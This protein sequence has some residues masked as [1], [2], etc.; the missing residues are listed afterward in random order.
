MRDNRVKDFFYPGNAVHGEPDYGLAENFVRTAEAFANTTYQSVYI[1]DYFRKN[2]L[3]VSPNPLFLCGMS[4]DAVKSE[5]YQFYID[6]VPAD[7]VEMLLEINKVGFSFFNDIPLEEKL[8]YTISY[9]FHL[10]NGREKILINHKLTALACQPDGSVWLG[11]SVVSLSTHSNPGHIT[12][13]C[14]GQ[15]EYW[16]YDLDFHC[17]EKRTTPML[18]ET[19]KEILTLSMQGLTINDI[20]ERIHRAV[21]SVKSA[22]RRLFEKLEV[23]NISEAISYATNY[24]LI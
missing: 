2:F 3:Y 11:L 6:H 22:R 15:S 4:A 9:D 8:K 14:R 10:V 24:K 20:A 19:E 7:E 23:N 5:G 1:I 16:E 13:H 18:N 21:D 12:M 17:W